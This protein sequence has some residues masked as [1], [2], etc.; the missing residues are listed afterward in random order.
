VDA[1]GNVD[2]TPA[3]LTW[4]VQTSSSTPPEP[5]PTPE[6]TPTGRCPTSGFAAGA[7]PPLCWR[8]FAAL[9]PFNRQVPAS[10]ALLAG[11]ADKAGYLAAQ[12]SPLPMGVNNADIAEDWLHPYFFAKSTDPLYSLH[13]TESWGR[14]T[15]EGMQIRVPAGARAAAG[16]DGHMTVI[17]PDGWEYSMWQVGPIPANGGTINMSWSHGRT[18]IDGDGLYGGGTAAWFSNLAGIIR[19][20][21]MEAGQINHALFAIARCTDGAAVYPAKAGTTARTCSSLGVG[22]GGRSVPL[23]ARL[24]LDM[25]DA[26]IDALA[27]PAWKKTIL[28]ALAHYGAI[29]GDTGAYGQKFSFGLQFES[30]TTYTAMGYPDKMAQWAAKNGFTSRPSYMSLGNVVDWNRM[31]VLHP[32]VSQ[33]SC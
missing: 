20:Q 27:A 29:V 9:S 21:E 10:P 8:P 22:S 11:S 15:V 25:T 17:Q 31:R 23:G 16:G 18:R 19:A 26:Q 6:P 24:R 33:G 32:C 14:C 3:T 2:A 13:C 5:E 7:W 4:T 30:G 12:G 1:A 28:K